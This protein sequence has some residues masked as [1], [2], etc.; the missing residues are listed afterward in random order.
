MDKAPDAF[1]TI[2]EV[3]EWLGVQA[4][5]LRFWESKFTQV[6]PVKRAGG[7]RYYRPSDM[8]LLGGIKALLHDD[9]MTIKGVQKTIK[10]QGIAHVSSLSPE[11]C[12]EVT[13]GA[14]TITAKATVLSFRP[15][16]GPATEPTTHDP[17]ADEIDQ[18]ATAETGEPADPPPDVSDAPPA[19]ADEPPAAQQPEPVLAA[20]AAPVEPPVG[21]NPILPSFLHRSAPPAFRPAPEPPAAEKTALV[22][23]AP[24]PPNEADLPYQPGPLARLAHLDALSATQAAE[25]APLVRQLRTWIGGSGGAGA[26]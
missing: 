18:A 21:E 3:A 6:K 15:V 4:H 9:G 25:I 5:V 10:E 2:S 24:D 22:V 13:Y 17:Q 12:D 11:L 16:T 8:Q 7:R 26:P 14:D 23:D 19:P 1:R 20:P